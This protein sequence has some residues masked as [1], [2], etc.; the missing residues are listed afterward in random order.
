MTSRQAVALTF[1]VNGGLFACLACR[2]PDIQHRWHFDDAQLGGIL[3][4]GAVGA[5]TG[6]AV[7]GRICS[8]FGSHRIVV[9]SGISAATLLAFFSILPIQILLIP[10]FFLF[11]GCASTMDVAMNVNGV[12]VEKDLGKPIMSALHGMFS[13]GGLSFG[14]VGWAL[15]KLHATVPEHFIG[16][17]SLFVLTLVTLYP[18]LLPA[19]PSPDSL[20]PAFALPDRRVVVV[21]LIGMCAFLCEGAMGDWSAIYLRDSLHQSPAMSAV[22]YLAFTLSMTSMRFGGDHLLERLGANVALRICG[23]I[24]AVGMGLALLVGNPI[25]TVI[26]FASVGIGMAVVAPIAFSLGGKIGGDNPDHAIASIATL[27]YSAFLFG[28]ALIGFIAKAESLRAALAIVVILA[29]AIT[30]LSGFI[31]RKADMIAS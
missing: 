1:F 25:T 11:G 20:A 22:G 6:V 23:T 8:R 27:S 16:V 13:L 26:G 4:S 2:L 18:R 14:L 7:A 5:V 15:L 3:F 17:C 29:V 9:L 10:V 12:A 24:T 30:L 28:P 31:D 21:G 19:I